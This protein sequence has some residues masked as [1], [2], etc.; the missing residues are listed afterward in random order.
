[1]EILKKLIKAQVKATKTLHN[2]ATAQYQTVSNEF[3]AKYGYNGGFSDFAAYL[4]KKEV[5]GW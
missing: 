1:M 4:A 3:A 2:M 5:F